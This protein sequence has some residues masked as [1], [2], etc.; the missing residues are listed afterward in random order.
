MRGH[1]R[2]RIVD[3][4]TM[5]P[6]RI[7]AAIA[8]LLVCLWFAIGIRQAID[9]DRA[10][11]IISSPAALSAGEAAHARSLLNDAGQLNPDRQIDLLRAQL[12][13]RLGH[14][15]KARALAL[16]VANSEPENSQAW[17]ELSHASAGDDTT[18]RMSYLHL[19]QLVPPFR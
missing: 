8:A 19:Y 6:A 10:T 17:L 18:L 2:T 5:S 12:D 13:V 4:W 7:L 15:A 16:S 14:D 9:T 3:D 11:A 1:Y